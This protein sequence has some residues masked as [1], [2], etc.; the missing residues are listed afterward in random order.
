MKKARKS[1]YTADVQWAQ[2]YH[3]GLTTGFV[4]HIFLEVY[5]GGRRC[6]FNSTNGEYVLDYD[7]TLN[8]ITTSASSELFALAKGLDS[9]HYGV[10]NGDDHKN[11]HLI[12]F[13]DAVYDISW[14][15][16]GYEV[17]FIE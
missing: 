15:Y 8:S 9:N 13:S 5:V 10:Y 7:Y 6:L 12:P 14:V 16:S 3:D 1:I 17:H 2:D 4:G 11:D